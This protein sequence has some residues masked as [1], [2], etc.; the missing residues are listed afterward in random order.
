MPAHW[1][2]GVSLLKQKNYPEAINELR[3]TAELAGNTESQAWL[4]YGYAVAGQ[5][6]KASEILNTLLELSKRQYVSPYQIAEIYTGLGDLD[7]AFQWWDK[8]RQAGFDPVYLTAW[9]ANDVLR[10]DPRYSAL[11]QQLGLPVPPRR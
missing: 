1:C 3:T 6:E 5:K 8:A 7:R 2:S 10:A 11:V 9:P 4:G